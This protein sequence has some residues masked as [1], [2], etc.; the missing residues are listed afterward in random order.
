MRLH[1]PEPGQKLFFGSVDDVARPADSYAPIHQESAFCAPCHFGAFNRTEVYSSYSEWLA[2]PYSDPATGQT[3]QDCHMP[4]IADSAV[5]PEQKPA[6]KAYFV[7]RHQGG[8]P[9]DPNTIHTHRMRGATDQDLLQNS[10]T[11]VTTAQA[12]GD[13]LQ[14]TVSITNDKTG[15]HAPTDVPLRHLILVVQAR[16]GQGNLLPLRD[17]ST[18]PDWTGNY[19][20]QPGKVFAKILEDEV[21]GESPA[22]A[23]WASIRVLTDTRIAAL[24]TDVT[25]YSFSA[26]ENGPITVEARLI[27]RRAF[28]Q[29]MLW[30]GWDDPDIL[31]EEETIVA[32]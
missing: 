30:K 2:S 32:R 29:L 24:A 19:A 17:G 23:F 22:M 25:R 21:T 7:F 28:Q 27:Y 26:P 1:R 8:V 18:L 16:D 15:H 10:V 9:R 4:P 14:V 13:E 20:A 3:C 31:M 11:M 5:F 12:A 6:D